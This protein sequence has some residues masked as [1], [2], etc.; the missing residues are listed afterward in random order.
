MTEK[1]TKPIIH[2]GVDHRGYCYKFELK[3]YLLNKGYEYIDH[4]NHRYQ[5]NDDY[6]EFALKV[7]KT[8]AK[9]TKKN[10]GI[11]ICGSGAGMVIAA[12]KF[13]CLRAAVCWNEK[14]AAAIK[15]DDD[16]QILVIPADYVTKKEMKKIV[17]KFLKTPFANQIKY[18]RRLKQI[19][20]YE[21][22]LKKS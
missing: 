15:H 3:K 1:Q 19:S 9:N 14:V 21:K 18:N 11:L 12:N 6:P 2:L 16:P 17:S 10:I 13:K 20:K 4:G 5:A 22:C 7:C 8:V